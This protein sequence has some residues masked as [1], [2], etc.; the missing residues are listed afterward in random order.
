MVQPLIIKRKND[1]ADKTR[2]ELYALTE[3][4][5]RTEE[6]RERIRNLFEELAKIRREE[7]RIL[8]EFT[9]NPQIGEQ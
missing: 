4:K 9:K 5:I 8:E 7:E 1:K 3:K 2:R 6:D